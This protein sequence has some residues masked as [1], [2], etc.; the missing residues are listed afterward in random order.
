MLGTDESVVKQDRD[1]PKVASVEVTKENSE[2]PL[3]TRTIPVDEVKATIEKWRSSIEA[4]YE[5]LVGKTKA[6]ESL[7]EEAFQELCTTH[8]VELIPGKSIHTIKAYT[9]RLKTSGVGCGNCQHGEKRTKLDTFSG[10]IV[11]HS[12]RL[13]LRNADLRQWTVRILDVTTDSLMRT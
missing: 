9:G 5:S 4:E 10:R 3:Q 8:V 1:V 12:L 7:S 13:M 11:A 6:V 2:V